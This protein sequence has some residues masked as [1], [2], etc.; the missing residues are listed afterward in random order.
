MFFWFIFP[1]PFPIGVLCCGSQCGVLC[2]DEDGGCVLCILFWFCCVRSLVKDMIV[3]RKGRRG[4]VIHAGI[5][6]EGKRRIAFSVAGVVGTVN[7]TGRRITNVRRVGSFRVHTVTSGV[8]GGV[9]GCPRTTGIRSVRSVMR[10]N[11]VRVHNCR[12]T[13]GCIHCH[14]GHRVSH[15][16][17]AASSNVLS[18]VRL[19]GR[20]M[21]R[22][23]SGG[24]PIVGSARHS[25]VTNRMSGS[26]A[27]HLLLPRR[28]IGTRSRNVVRFRS[29]SCFTRGRRGY[30][31]VGL[32]SVLR[33]NAIVDRAVVRG[34]RSFFATYGMA[35]RVITRIT[36]GR[37]NNRSFALSRLTPFISVD[38]RGVGGRIVRRQG[39]ANRS[40]GS[41]VVSGVIRTHL[42]RRVGDNVRAVRC[43]LVA[44]VA[45]GNRTPFIAVFVCL[46]RM[47]GNHA[48][49]SLT[50]VVGRILLREVGKMGGRGN[51]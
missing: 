15:G 36:S 35:A 37:C 22:R 24:G 28:V 39:L 29:T 18:L 19:G 21:G 4:I 9:S 46:S 1:V 38:H 49:S 43:R 45:Y 2:H 42:R 48:H 11:V 33:G 47:P 7:G 34:P 41:R 25:C 6:G 26:L 40:V 32:R 31:L 51:M 14:C 5:V 3:R 27:H 50:V 16:D 8:T 17:G 44:L 23:G 12:M 13:R 30:S 10:A 20:R